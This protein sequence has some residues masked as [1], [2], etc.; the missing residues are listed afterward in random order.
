MISVVLFAAVVA[1]LALALGFYAARRRR[2]LETGISVGGAIVCATLAA[3]A[4]AATPPLWLL[5]WAFWVALV[6]AVLGGYAYVRA[7]L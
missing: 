2:W 7:A 5:L 1:L 6:L 4:T 3:V